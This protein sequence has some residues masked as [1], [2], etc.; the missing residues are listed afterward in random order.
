M[1]FL[2]NLLSD[3]I[4]NSTGFNAKPFVR[5]VGG[6]NILLLGTLQC[7]DNRHTAVLRQSA[8]YVL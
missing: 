5:A 3:L 1:A 6:K 7:C 8:C 2:D 4:R